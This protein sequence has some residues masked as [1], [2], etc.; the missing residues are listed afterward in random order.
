[1][2]DGSRVPSDLRR[3]SGRAVERRGPGDRGRGARLPCAAL[4]RPWIPPGRHRPPGFARPPRPALAPAQ[5]SREA[6]NEARPLPA[7]RTRPRRTRRRLVMSRGATGARGPGRD[8]GFVVDAQAQPPPCSSRFPTSA[9]KSALA[10]LGTCFRLGWKLNLQKSPSNC[11]TF[12]AANEFVGI[13]AVGMACH[14]PGWEGRDERS[15]DD[16]G[17]HPP[18]RARGNFARVPADG[19]G[20]CMWW[21]GMRV[22]RRAAAR[23]ACERSRSAARRFPAKPRRSGCRG[24]LAPPLCRD[25]MPCAP[26]VFCI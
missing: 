10:L 11:K 25:I 4:E 21:V 16:R 8:G 14:K 7:R 17:S 18:V 2:P 24:A 3:N 13:Y 26:G 15:S 1:V 12:A 19:A 20:R 22:C 6:R 9:W 5:I 23:H